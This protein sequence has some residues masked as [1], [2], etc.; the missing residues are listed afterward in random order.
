MFGCSK[1]PT[2]AS[3]DPVQKTEQT[4]SK[5]IVEKEIFDVKLNLPASL[6]VGKDLESVKKDALA[7]GVHDV[8]INGDGSLTYIMSKS[9]YREMMDG[10]AKSINDNISEFLAKEENKSVFKEIVFNKDYSELTIKVDSGHYNPAN[11]FSLVGFKIS[12]MMYQ[13]FNG[14]DKSRMVIKAN[15]M[16][17]NG[18]M[19]KTSTMDSNGK[20][21]K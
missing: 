17:S 20:M 5:V 15:I 10:I 14:V 3:Q 19:I 13:A 11:E 2:Q 21:I 9:K 7:Q 4:E 12:S 18:T 6:F 16:D 8:T 1:S